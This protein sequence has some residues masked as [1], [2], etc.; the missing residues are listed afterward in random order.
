MKQKQWTH[1]TTPVQTSYQFL[2][3]TRQASRGE[4]ILPFLEMP[5][6]SERLMLPEKKWTGR[7]R[8]G[9]GWKA[10]LCVGLGIS[11]RKEAVFCTTESTTDTCD[12]VLESQFSEEDIYLIW[13]D[14]AKLCLQGCITCIL[15]EMASS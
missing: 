5:D 12:L 9:S 10:G 6:I 11:L 15:L 8:T 2:S 13:G 7:Q 14:L 1:C 4:T 3:P